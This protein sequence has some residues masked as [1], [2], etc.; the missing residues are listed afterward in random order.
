M[1][2]YWCFEFIISCGQSYGETPGSI[3]CCLPL[4]PS[5]DLNLNHG[6]KKKTSERAGVPRTGIA[7]I[8]C[9]P[10]ILALKTVHFILLCCNSVV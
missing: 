2:F 7:C 3:F 8:S 1:L 5:A 10:F 6:I 4:K 9:T